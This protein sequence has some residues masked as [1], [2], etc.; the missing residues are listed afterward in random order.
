[1]GSVVSSGRGLMEVT[2][3]GTNTAIGK[4]ADTLGQ[5]KKEDTPLQRNSHPRA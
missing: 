5:T 1:M 3:T 4:V 2:M